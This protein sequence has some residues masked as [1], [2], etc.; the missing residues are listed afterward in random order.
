MK[1]VTA[2]NLAEGRNFEFHARM[3]SRVMGVR[4]HFHRAHFC[5]IP[6]RPK[7]VGGGCFNRRVRIQFLTYFAGNIIRDATPTKIN[8]A[9]WV[10]MN[11]V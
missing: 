6:K 11:E 7:N 4:R 3:S 10:R 5:G 1:T 9:S 2:A 8:G